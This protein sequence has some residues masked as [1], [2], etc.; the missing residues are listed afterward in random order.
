MHLILPAWI[1]ISGSTVIMNKFIFEAFDFHYPIL[2]T[3][4]H[5]LFCSFCV[6]LLCEKGI[7]QKPEERLITSKFVVKIA[8]VAVSFA[9]SVYLSNAAYMYLSVVY[10]QMLKSINVLVVYAMGCLLGVDCFERKTAGRL[11]VVSIGVLLASY[12]ESHFSLIGFFFQIGSTFCESLRLILSQKLMQTEKETPMNSVEMMY[13]VSPV[14]FLSLTPLFFIVE[15]PTIVDK[16]GISLPLSILAINLFMVFSLN[17]S[18][19]AVIKQTSALVI[20]LAGV[21]KDWAIISVLSVGFSFFTPSI[22]LAGYLIAFDGVLSY[23]ARRSDQ[24][25]SEKNGAYEMVN[26]KEEESIEGGSGS[27]T[28]SFVVSTLSVDARTVKKAVIVAIHAVVLVVIAARQIPDPDSICNYEWRGV[29][30]ASTR[31]SEVEASLVISHC[32]HDMSH[33]RE[34]TEGFAFKDVFVYSKCGK[35]TKSAPKGAKVFRLPNYGREAYAWAHHISKMKKNE[36]LI[37][38]DVTFFMKDTWLKPYGGVIPSSFRTMMETALSAQ[39][40]SCGMLPEKKKTNAFWLEK[41]D[42]SVWHDPKEFQL[43]DSDRTYISNGMNY[44]SVEDEVPFW[45]NQTFKSWLSNMGVSINEESLVPVCYNG[46][47]AVSSTSV[48]RTSEDLFQKLSRSLSR[49]SNILEG[50]YAERVWALLFKKPLTKEESGKISRAAVRT[51]DPR[52]CSATRG[53]LEG[54]DANRL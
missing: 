49:G 51:C 30:K 27:T 31:P 50:G 40:F 16:G 19:Y 9:M 20:N 5:M 24:N 17:L 35:N 48:R 1:F 34:W 37:P 25:S 13:Y 41:K 6:R 32:A 22:Q 33:I 53:Q 42:A 18:S 14:A 3:A 44:T 46:N 7:L 47:F 10:I 15:L 29:S 12:G 26:R 11:C 4:S 43:L 52:R 21:V 54:C 2:L 45:T 8:P 23:N 38:K 39:G 28:K 36:S